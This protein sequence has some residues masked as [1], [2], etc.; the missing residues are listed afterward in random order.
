M[1]HIH[2]G[3]CMWFSGKI[4]CI[5]LWVIRHYFCDIPVVVLILSGVAHSVHQCAF[6]HTLLSIRYYSNELYYL[7]RY[8]TAS[9]SYF[10]GSATR[11]QLEACEFHTCT[12]PRNGA[13]PHA[14]ARVKSICAGF[15]FVSDQSDRS[16]LFAR[17]QKSY[18]R[19]TQYRFFSPKVR[20]VEARTS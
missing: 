5:L 19:C 12:R 2:I 17:A 11:M 4:K 18:D 20:Q 14:F 15:F 10:T 8:I 1:S 9:K 6:L 7:S 16:A 13:R 3:L